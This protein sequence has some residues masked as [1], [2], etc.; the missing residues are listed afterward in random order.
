MAAL[1]LESFSVMHV[2]LSLMGS[3]NVKHFQTQMYFEW[4]FTM[5]LLDFPS[6]QLSCSHLYTNTYCNSN[7]FDS[8]PKGLFT[9]PIPNKRKQEKKEVSSKL[10]GQFFIGLAS[11]PCLFFIRSRKLCVGHLLGSWVSVLPPSGK[12][13][14]PSRWQ[15]LS[16]LWSSL[17]IHDTC[18]D[19]LGSVYVVVSM[20]GNGEKSCVFRHL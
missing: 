20:C 11:A 9:E 17:M 8:I 5:R 19:L 12:S 3:Y 15:G 4:L 2:S 16:L 10:A 18:S 6:L 14:M 13:A 7:I 1:V